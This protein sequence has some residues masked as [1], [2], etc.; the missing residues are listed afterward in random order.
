VPN[1]LDPREMRPL[2]EPG[3]QHSLQR[4]HVA[5]LRQKGLE[6]AARESPAR[7]P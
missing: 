7:S 4:G 2:T 1:P 3:R 5:T 6:P